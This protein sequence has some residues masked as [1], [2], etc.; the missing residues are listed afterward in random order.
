ME[1]Q[2][3]QIAHVLSIIPGLLLELQQDLSVHHHPAH[4][5]HGYLTWWE[6]IAVGLID[7]R[8]VAPALATADWGHFPAPQDQEGSGLEIGD[9]WWLGP[10]AGAGLDGGTG[11]SRGGGDY[12][13]DSK[14]GCLPTPFS[15]LQSH[16]V[17]IFAIG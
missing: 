5:P 2:K 15:S 13:A 6:E 8:L 10:R 3:R 1:S 4:G 9:W 14:P 12:P 16:R 17:T 7:K 11:V